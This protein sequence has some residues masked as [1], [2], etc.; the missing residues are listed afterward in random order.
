MVDESAGTGATGSDGAPGAAGSGP[1]RTTLRVLSYN[2]KSLQADAAAVRDVIRETDPDVV[3]VQEPC[4]YLTGGRRRMRA[5]AAATGTVCVVPG[6]SPFG[7]YTTA[8][9]VARRHADAVVRR[10]GRPLSWRWWRRRDLRAWPT[11]RGSALVDLG[12][13]V[14]VSVHLGLDARERLEHCAEVTRLVE[15]AGADRCVVAGDLNEEPGGPAWQALG[16]VLRDAVP[17]APGLT[18]PA[19]RPV[20]RID[21]VLVG[22]GFEVL[23]S[24]VLR[25]PAALRGSDHLPVLVE[26]APLRR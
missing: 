1:G 21:G 4:R 13:V 24:T 3:A 16:S 11:R 18:F 20:R 12:D 26:L 9:L 14:V 19:P 10:R 23:S 22:A 2:V 17:E 5:L 8:L 7:A 15:E 6:G 25:T